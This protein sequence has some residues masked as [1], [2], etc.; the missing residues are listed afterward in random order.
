[1]SPAPGNPPRRRCALLGLVTCGVGDAA[2]A[3]STTDLGLE[4]V[5][6]VRRAMPVTPAGGGHDY[7]NGTVLLPAGSVGRAAALRV[8]VAHQLICCTQHAPIAAG[9]RTVAAHASSC[10]L[11]LLSCE[12]QHCCS[13]RSSLRRSLELSSWIFRG[14]V[15]MDSELAAESAAACS[16]GAGRDRSRLLVVRVAFYLVRS[17]EIVQLVRVYCMYITLKIRQTILHHA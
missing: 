10:S 5:A 12:V 3:A 9:G 13:W 4:R 8:G 17:R 1:M 2:E 7:L 15:A 11:Q 16:R 6:A 14:G